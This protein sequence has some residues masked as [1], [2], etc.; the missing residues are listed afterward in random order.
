MTR[1]NVDQ[2]G[3]KPHLIKAL[4]HE[5]KLRGVPMTVLINDLLTKVLISTQ[6]M[7]LAREKI[8]ATGTSLCVCLSATHHKPMT[9]KEFNPVRP[10]DKRNHEI[11]GWS[12]VFG[13]WISGKAIPSIRLEL[14]TV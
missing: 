4:Y 1:Q 6:R 8:P 3:V 12:Q 13:C 14:K 11:A 10:N 2:P 7:H 9:I 5:A